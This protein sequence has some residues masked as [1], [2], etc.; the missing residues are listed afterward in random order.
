[1]NQP[2]F[3]ALVQELGIDKLSAE[4]QKT[5]LEIALSTI[6]K[7]MSIR[8]AQALSADQIDQFEKAAKQGDQAEIERLYPDFKKHYQEEIDNLKQD[9]LAITPSSH[10]S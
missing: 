3:T 10:L 5:V 6:E 8:I 9:I 2:D 4:D 1:M 7:R